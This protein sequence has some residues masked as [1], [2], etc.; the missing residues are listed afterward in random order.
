M[1]A[2]FLRSDKETEG[3]F[4]DWLQRGVVCLALICSFLSL[5]T[6]LPSPRSS[7][8]VWNWKKKWFQRLKEM[9]HLVVTRMLLCVCFSVSVPFGTGRTPHLME[10]RA[11]A[12]AERAPL[13][14]PPSAQAKSEVKQYHLWGRNDDEST[15]ERQRGGPGVVLCISIVFSATDVNR[16]AEP[17]SNQSLWLTNRDPFFFFFFLILLA[18]LTS[19]NYS[20]VL[21]NSYESLIKV[22]QPRNAALH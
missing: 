12:E 18:F 14:S 15:A 8:R 20:G 11:D 10:P 4:R 3:R 1:S 2:C 6:P 19:V 13:C 22:G 17:A 7:L 5:C 21:R 16:D 9:H